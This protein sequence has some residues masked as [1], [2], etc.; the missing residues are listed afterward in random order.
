VGTVVKILGSFLSSIHLLIVNNAFSTIFETG[1][2]SLNFSDEAANL[3]EVDLDVPKFRSLVSST[4]S[5]VHELGEIEPAILSSGRRDSSDVF[6]T[7]GTEGA[8]S[9]EFSA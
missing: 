5:D 7:E 3:M 4:S 2:E 6:V 9:G 1:S 8:I